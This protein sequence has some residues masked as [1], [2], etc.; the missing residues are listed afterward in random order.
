MKQALA[1]LAVALFAVSAFSTF[2]AAAEKHYAPGV[3][4]DEIKIGQ[5]LPLSGPASA[6]GQ[7]GRAEAAY[8]RMVNETG[9]V[10]GRKITFVQL[11]D[12]Y[13]PPRTVEQT[14]KL[15]EQEQVAL[16]F[17]TIGTPTNLAIRKYLNDK[18]VPQ[19]WIGSGGDQ[20]S[21]PEH[22][23]WTIPFLPSYMTEGRIY[24]KYILANKPDAKIAV[25]YQNDDFGKDLFEGLKQGL[26]PEGAKRIVAT[27]SYEVSDPT[28]AQQ[29]LTLQGSGA[30]TLFTAAT[31]KFSAQAIRTVHDLG[32][33]PLY[34]VNYTGSAVA[35][36]L[37]PA[38]L[39]KAVGL[40][41]TAY[42][43]DPTDPQWKDDPGFGQWLAWMHK[44]MAE[45][46]IADLYNVT[47]Y[48]EAAV[49]AQLLRQCGDD[50]TRE[51]IMNQ[52]T[53][54]TNLAQPMLQ[55]GITMNTSPDNYFPVKQMRLVRFDGK[56]WVPFGEAIDGRLTQ[57]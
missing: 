30:D 39:D 9:G 10:N 12:G 20:F 56:T 53:H 50:L 18:K 51:N 23:P 54:I 36:V 49:L 19:L 55:P 52:A 43:K 32:W 24:G 7:I 11:D 37:V 6:Y 45:G 4:D 34:F 40:I 26:G 31:P 13:S 44:Y 16:I 2:A 33:K 57:R 35:A 1:R 21:D 28:V 38:G 48:T 17:S 22:F 5:T 42:L 29:I 14:R 15:V 46:D 8:F 25:L 41:S 3:S 27:A 47:G